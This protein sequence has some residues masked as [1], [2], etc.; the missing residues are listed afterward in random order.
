[1]NMRKTLVRECNRVSVYSYR[2]N[3]FGDIEFNSREFHE[4]EERRIFIDSTSMYIY[5]YVYIIYTVYVYI[6][7]VCFV[8]HLLSLFLLHLFVYL[9]F[10]LDIMYIIY[11]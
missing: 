8:I 3:R 9:L 10:Y 6:T 1:M 5:V 7:Y 4:T 2:I 11:F